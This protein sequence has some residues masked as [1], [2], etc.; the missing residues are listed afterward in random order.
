MLSAAGLCLLFTL[1]APPA[2]AARPPWFEYDR[3]VPLALRVEGSKRQEGVEV[4]R[5]SFSGRAPKERVT[6]YLVQP[7]GPGPRAAVL[8]VHWLGEPAT[9]NSTQFLQEAIG[10]AHFGVVSLLVDAMWATPGW[11]SKQHFE[12]DFAASA[13]QVVE[14][15]RAMDALLAQPGV[16]PKRLAFVGHDFGAMYGVL[17]G[18]ADPRPKAYVL[19]AGTATFHEWY[20]LRKEQPK[21]KAAYVKQMEVLDVT[22]WIGRLAPASVLLQF[23]QEDEY[24]PLP[25]A[26]AL[27]DAAREPK[28]SRF[29]STTHA[30]QSTDTVNERFRWLA[31]ELGLPPEP[32]VRQDAGAPK[33]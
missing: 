19:L 10:L 23:A 7:P 32:A 15:R 30:M 5:V 8:Y 6:G 12:D 20:L 21:D 28:L 27:I 25:R 26:R 4:K 16:D 31:K 14:L 22:R 24:V 13:R 2:D 33:R 3:S 9:S 11:F 17:A 1:G 29:Y 18:A